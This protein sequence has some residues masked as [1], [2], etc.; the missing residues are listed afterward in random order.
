M[1]KDDGHLYLTQLGPQ[2]KPISPHAIEII[3]L[4]T[5]KNLTKLMYLITHFS[6][7]LWSFLSTKGIKIVLYGKV[8]S[9]LRRHSRRKHSLERRITNTFFGSKVSKII[10]KPDHRPL[11][12]LGVKYDARRLVDSIRNRNFFLQSL[13]S[14]RLVYMKPQDQS[15]SQN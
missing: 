15:F 1:V 14:D 10:E 13:Q 11:R 7:D 2:A 4:K 12:N 6:F 9:E 3:I 8:N 5:P